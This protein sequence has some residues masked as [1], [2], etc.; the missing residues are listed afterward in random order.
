MGV[1]VTSLVL[2]V[3]VVLIEV[4]FSGYL[5]FHTKVF[6]SIYGRNIIYGT[7]H[8]TIIF[9]DTPKI[10]QIMNFYKL[11][12]HEKAKLKNKHKK[13]KKHTKNKQKT[14]T[15]KNKKPNTIPGTLNCTRLALMTGPGGYC[16][17]Y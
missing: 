17:G 1:V 11:E 13:A 7:F 9:Y 2:L 16:E 12:H 6:I 15:R 14:K 3:A 5:S 8:H 4:L 10:C